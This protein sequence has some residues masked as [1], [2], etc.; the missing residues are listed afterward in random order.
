MS[1]FSWSLEA[2]AAAGGIVRGFGFTVAGT[3]AA[4]ATVS[5]EHKWIAMDGFR[6]C[7]RN[8]NV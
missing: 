7:G 1:P 8:R 4:A 2:V 6:I 3:M 5:V